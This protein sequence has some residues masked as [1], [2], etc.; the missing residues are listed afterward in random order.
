MISSFLEMDGDSFAAAGCEVA[1]RGLGLGTWMNLEHFMIG[2][3]G[4]ERLIRRELA[5]ALGEEGERGFFDAFLDSF[6]GEDDA[7]YLEGLGVNALRVAVNYR[8][9]L[10]DEDPSRYL[11]E[12]FLRLDRLIEACRG[13]GIYVVIDLHAAPGGQNPDWHSDNATGLSQFWTYKV[14]RDQMAALWGAIA[15]RYADEPAVGAYD[16]LNEPF[17]V[18]SF[19]ALADYYDSALEAIRR[20]DSRH[21]VFLEGR[22]FAMDFSGFGEPSDPRTTY[23]FHFYPNVWH[24]E[25]FEES[26]SAARRAGL[27]E[28][29]LKPFLELRERVGRPLWCGECGFTYEEDRAGRTR[30]LT[31]ELLSLFERKGFPWSLWAYKDAGAMGILHPRA[32]SAWTR[33]ARGIG[34]S[35]T[36]PKEMED[37]RE[38]LKSMGGRFFEPLSEDLAYDLQFRLRTIF[39][40]AYARQALRPAIEAAGLDGM[41]AGSRSFLFAECERRED[42]AGVIAGF[43]R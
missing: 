14:F 38:A 18:P 20:R 34:R 19:G 6:F 1:L 32:D 39:H 36:L 3:P 21:L 16:L 23:S 27:L 35:W 7:R 42:I 17:Q 11:E 41:L 30:A 10:D 22:R 9:F 4:P 40:E 12:G 24:P 28:S 37:A 15:D 26:T 13:R 8:Y 2:M 25:V 29:S 43:R 5:A 33:F 31:E